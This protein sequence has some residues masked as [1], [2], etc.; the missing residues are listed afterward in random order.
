[1]N[2]PNSSLPTRSHA[3]D[4][5]PLATPQ[6]SV[7][8][9]PQTFLLMDEPGSCGFVVEAFAALRDEVGPMCQRPFVAWVHQ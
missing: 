6:S 5:S 3:T 1:M 7:P 8:P 4:S 2:P 9:S